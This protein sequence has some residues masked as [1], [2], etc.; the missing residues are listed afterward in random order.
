MMF[1]EDGADEAPAAEP[2]FAKVDNLL[3]YAAGRL[4]GCGFHFVEQSTQSISR[5]YRLGHRTGLLRLGDHRLP[6]SYTEGMRQPVWSFLTFP[7]TFVAKAA[8]SVDELLYRAVGK[9]IVRAGAENGHMIPE[10]FWLAPCQP[11]YQMRL[12]GDQ[13]LDRAF[14]KKKWDVA[15]NVYRSMRAAHMRQPEDV[16]DVDA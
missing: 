11:S 3:E 5:Y 12:K 6:R 9:Y 1:V 4:E 10:G 15:G 2:R 16:D 14:G 13:A 8:T 7:E